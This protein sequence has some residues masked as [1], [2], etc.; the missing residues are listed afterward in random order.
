MSSKHV[1]SVIVENNLEDSLKEKEE[2]PKRR[3]TRSRKKAEPI[4][5]EPLHEAEVDVKFEIQ[6]EDLNFELVDQTS[7]LPDDSKEFLENLL[8]GND[9]DLI[10]DSSDDSIPLSKSKKK[11]RKV[12]NSITNKKLKDPQDP[13]ERKKKT[14]E[15]EE[16]IREYC[17]LICDLCPYNFK[18]YKDVKIHFRQNHPG[19]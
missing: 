3:T 9:T 10:D 6:Q 14:Q 19:E 7:A 15:E 12:K 18:N 4:K 1:E 2:L 5:E 11:S 16:L 13:V 8:K 17:K